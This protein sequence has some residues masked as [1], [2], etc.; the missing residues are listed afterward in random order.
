M[1][2]CVCGS[3]AVAFRLQTFTAPLGTVP[4][5]SATPTASLPAQQ[6]AGTTQGQSEW[7]DFR[8]LIFFVAESN[9]TN[10]AK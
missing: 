5:H 3:A 2:V 6:S 8:T 10:I 7:N 9:L 4:T 1:C